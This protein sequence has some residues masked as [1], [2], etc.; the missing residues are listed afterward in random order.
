[1][2][3]ESSSFDWI[4]VEH[5][6]WNIHFRGVLQGGACMLSCWSDMWDATPD[7]DSCE[8]CLVC[9][10][11][12]TKVSIPCMIC[13]G[14]QNYLNVAGVV[15]VA[16]T[17]E[18]ARGALIPEYVSRK[19]STVSTVLFWLHALLGFAEYLARNTRSGCI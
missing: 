5:A 1:M 10:W 2:A 17:V 3:L 16:R 8:H 12:G 11:M 14:A 15:D 19:V 4:V 7:I 9:A 6:V 18:I 13:G